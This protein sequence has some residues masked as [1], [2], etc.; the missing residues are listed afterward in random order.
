MNNNKKLKIALSNAVEAYIYRELVYNYE[1][2][3]KEKCPTCGLSV[4]ISNLLA[5]ISKNDY[6]SMFEIEVAD[7]VYYGT[8][9]MYHGKIYGEEMSGFFSVEASNIDDLIGEVYQL[10]GEMLN[11]YKKE[12]DSLD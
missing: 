6:H 8:V 4:P 2:N 3:V 12:V 5:D 9:N 1:G 10:S 11:M 7:G